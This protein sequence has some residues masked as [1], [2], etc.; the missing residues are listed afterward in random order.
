MSP[1]ANFFV[2]ILLLLSAYA[3][4]FVVD[5]STRSDADTS[6]YRQ[7]EITIVMSLIS[8]VV[9]NF[10]DIVSL[11]ENYHP[12][13]AMR[14]MLARIMAL[15]LLSLY[16]LIFALFGKTDGMIHSLLKMEQMKNAGINFGLDTVTPVYEQRRDC[17][18]IPIPCDVLER[19]FFTVE[20]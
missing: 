1:L 4:I 16:T 2:L 19:Y 18:Q 7:N 11:L 9:P 15:N 10:F 3:V 8:L 13:K 5:R 17:Y 6:W 14:W 12:R 20:I